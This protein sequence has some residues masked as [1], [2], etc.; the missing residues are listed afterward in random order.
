MFYLNTYSL[1]SDILEAID[2]IYYSGRN[3]NTADG[4]CLMLRGFSEEHGAR[5][6][7]SNVFRLA[8][9]MTDGHSGGQSSACGFRSTLGVAQMVHN[10]SHPIVTF[11]IGVTFNVNTQ[12]LEAIASKREYVTYLASFGEAVF[13][14]T[15]DE[16]T[17]ELCEKSKSVRISF[18]KNF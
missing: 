13:R 10:F 12:E 16:Q 17:Y 4:L 5:L 14:E 1:K 7:E 6:S 11:A 15:R 8:I 9:V 3:T 2:G 18:L